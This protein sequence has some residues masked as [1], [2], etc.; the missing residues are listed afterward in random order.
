[1]SN[2]LRT[3]WETYEK[4]KDINWKPE[5]E[6]WNPSSELLPPATENCVG[7]GANW[8]EQVERVVEAILV[9]LILVLLSII[10]YWTRCKRNRQIVDSRPMVDEA[11]C[12]SGPPSYEMVVKQE[13]EQLDD[14]SDLPTYWQAVKT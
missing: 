11:F 2:S 14:T 7:H 6:G 3:Y 5:L 1:M 8:E 10:Y 12:L 4:S 13:K 9:L